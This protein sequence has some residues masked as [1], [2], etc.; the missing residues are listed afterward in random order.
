MMENIQHKN[1]LRGL[2]LYWSEH[3]PCGAERNRTS[4]NS[5]CI[6]VNFDLYLS[7]FTYKLALSYFAYWFSAGDLSIELEK[8]TSLADFNLKK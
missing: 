3:C 7:S 1:L 5:A 4:W 8:M 2:E 6:S